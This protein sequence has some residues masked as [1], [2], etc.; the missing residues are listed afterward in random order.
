MTKL[1]TTDT[2]TAWSKLIR[3]EQDLMTDIETALKAGNLP[4]LRW[5]DVL[6][7]L[8]REG[9]GCLRPKDLEDRL[10]LSQ[11]NIS[12][13]IDRMAKA[14]FVRIK[15]LQ[16]DKRA[17]RIELTTQGREA[18]E[19]IWEVYGPFIQ[20]RIGQKLSPTETSQLI[21]LLEKLR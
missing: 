16:E 17:Q 10:L 13:L 1:P 20:E 11:Y 12:R 2:M 3:V 19:G 6:L 8:S 14:G 18:K 4:P 9:D 7:E 15:R 5:Y 21:Q